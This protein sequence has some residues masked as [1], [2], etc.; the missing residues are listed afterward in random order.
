[1]NKVTFGV[2]RA[3]LWN[4]VYYVLSAVIAAYVG[5][6]EH[7]AWFSV[8]ILVPL[9]II[10]GSTE[11][12]F[13]RTLKRMPELKKWAYI[14]LGAKCAGWLFFILVC[15]TV[16]SHGVAIGCIITCAVF[17]FCAVACMW[18]KIRKIV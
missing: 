16:I 5:V 13:S 18:L 9:A 8:L 3:L 1:M 11:I 17:S 10:V 7:V 12:L 15:T 14:D 4:A 6:N 2:L